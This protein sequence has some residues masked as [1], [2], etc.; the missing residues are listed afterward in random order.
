MWGGR[1]TRGPA[2]V[3]EEINAS[4]EF[5]KRLALEDIAGS[6]AHAEMLAAQ[7]IINRGDAE[8]IRRGLEEIRTEIAEGRFD[9]RR[10]RKT[11]ISTSRHGLPN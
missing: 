10:D 6:R 3:M 11:F 1:F 4:I 2:A 5:D 8:A 9:F 7:N